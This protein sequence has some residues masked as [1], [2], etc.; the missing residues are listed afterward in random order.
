MYVYYVFVSLTGNENQS[1]ELQ[2]Q[3]LRIGSF[4]LKAK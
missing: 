2:Q 1:C 4:P 3:N